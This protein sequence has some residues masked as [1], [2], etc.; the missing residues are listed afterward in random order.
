LV[1]SKSRVSSWMLKS[2]SE[3]DWGVW[4]NGSLLVEFVGYLALGAV[5]VYH[6][7]FLIQ[8]PLVG[9]TTRIKEGVRYT[10]QSF[11]CEHASSTK[12]SFI[13]F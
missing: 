11:T 13:P 9:L 10:S 12:V 8:I 4:D 5:E 2:T 6:T 7:L 3:A 1:M